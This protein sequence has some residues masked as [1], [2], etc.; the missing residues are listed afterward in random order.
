MDTIFAL[1]S[2]PGKAGV[3]IIR[4][5]G[6]LARTAAELLAGRSLADRGMTLAMLRDRD[7][8][9]LDQVLV[10]SFAAPHSFTGENIVELQAHGSMAVV[11][12][13]L[14]SLSEMDGL[15]LA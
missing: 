7:G 8:R 9:R 10:L 1:A 4:I 2:A 3:A 11:S 5:S 14:R 13:I 6:A 15:R 12:A